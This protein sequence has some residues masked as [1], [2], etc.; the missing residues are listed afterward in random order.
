MSVPSRI[1]SFILVA[2]MIPPL[3]ACGGA[4]PA[5][6]PDAPASARGEVVAGSELRMDSALLGR[7]MQES[8]AMIARVRA[9]LAQMR[10]LPPERWSAQLPEHLAVVDSMLSMMQRHEREEGAGMHAPM[11]PGYAPMTPGHAP[12]GQ[13]RGMGAAMHESMS[14]AMHEMHAEMEMLRGASPAVLREWMPAHLE[15]LEQMVS[16]MEA[17][18]VRHPGM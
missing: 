11:G 7:H 6:A 4:A 13:G 5:P 18:H 15:H 1:R 8:E 16:M 12:M 17:M 14:G 9:D 2:L 3:H 10:A